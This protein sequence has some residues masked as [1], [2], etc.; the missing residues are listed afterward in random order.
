MFRLLLTRST[1]QLLSRAC[2]LHPLV[3]AVCVVGAFGYAIILDAD[4]SSKGARQFE[5]EMALRRQIEFERAAEHRRLLEIIE[6]L[7][8]R[9][10]LSLPAEPEEDF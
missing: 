7:K 6:A 2:A 9:R 1:I 4:Q 5:Q 10:D 8:P 3:A